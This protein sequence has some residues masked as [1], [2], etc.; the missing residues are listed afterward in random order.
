[1]YVAGVCQFPYGASLSVGCIS[2]HDS[3]VSI[4]F[5]NGDYGSQYS[6]WGKNVRA[7]WS[8]EKR[9]THRTFG[10]HTVS[11]SGGDDLYV[12]CEK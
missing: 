7:I 10:K 2:S 5:D 1:L 11:K 6:L 4:A 3:G 9:K 8:S 12:T